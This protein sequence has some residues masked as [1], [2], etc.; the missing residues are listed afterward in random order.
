M[1]SSVRATPW[2]RSGT[3]STSHTHDAQCTP[4]MK[5]STSLSPG[6][7][8]RTYNRW[9]DSWSNSSNARRVERTANSRFSPSR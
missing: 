1:S 8:S 3:R 5:S 9:N 4:S 7:S 2:T 6:V